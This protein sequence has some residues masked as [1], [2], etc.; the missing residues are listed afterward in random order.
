MRN[1][2]DCKLKKWKPSAIRNLQSAHVRCCFTNPASGGGRLRRAGWAAAGGVVGW[3]ARGDCQVRGTGA[4]RNTVVARSV[5][6]P[7]LLSR[8]HRIGPPPVDVPPNRGQTMVHSW[9]FW[10]R[11]ITTETRRARS[12]EVICHCNFVIRFSLSV[13]SVPPWFITCHA[14]RRAALQNELLVSRRRFARQ[15]AGRA[16]EDSGLSSPGGDGSQQPGR[17]GAGPHGRQGRRAAARDRRG[18]YAGG[19]AAGG[20]VGDRSRQL[21]PAVQIAD[22]RPAFGAKRRV[23]AKVGGYRRVQSRARGRSPHRQAAPGSAGD[24]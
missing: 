19:C 1:A 15:R 4:N 24:L 18:N 20:A 5:G 13:L 23:R 8:R 22:T 16:G 2:R 17:G 9:N 11:N 21:C 3:A 12:E 6:P 14:L 7:R 10:M